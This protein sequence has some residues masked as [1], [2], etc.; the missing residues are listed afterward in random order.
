GARRGRIPGL[1]ALLTAFQAEDRWQ[2]DQ[3]FLRDH[4]HPL[5]RRDSMVHDEWH[6]RCGLPFPTRRLEYEFVGQSVDEHDAAEPRA[7]QQLKDALARQHRRRLTRPLARA[8]F[9][10][11][12]WPPPETLLRLARRR[13]TWRGG[14]QIFRRALASFRRR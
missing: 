2:T 3:E 13:P 9:R 1:R 4:V 12:L 8:G 7:M 5:V 6:S 11:G 14:L 10:M